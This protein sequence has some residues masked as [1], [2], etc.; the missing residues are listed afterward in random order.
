MATF[1]GKQFGNAALH[2]ARKRCD[3]V[4]DD[5]RMTLHTS[6][7][8]PD[9][10][11][12]LWFSDVSNEL[13]TAGGYTVGGVALANKTVAYTAGTN[14]VTFDADDITISNSTLTWRTA[15]LVD[16]T[17]GTAGTNPVLAYYQGD[18]DTVSTGGPTTI[19]V[20]AGGLM[21]FVAA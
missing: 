13:S 17:P 14:T 12:D 11:A 10:D 16:A 2:I 7:F 9:Q 4:N 18:A 3:L 1:T 19:T 5:I 20:A 6:T 15:V 21:T 8:A